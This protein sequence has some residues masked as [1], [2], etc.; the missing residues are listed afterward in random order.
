MGKVQTEKQ[1]KLRDE[2]RELEVTYDKIGF[3]CHPE[4]HY[5]YVRNEEDNVFIHFNDSNVS[6]SK[7]HNETLYPI[8]GIL[9]SCKEN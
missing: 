6:E 3:I 9:Y 2:L 1:L 5:T 4:F 8:K 7:S